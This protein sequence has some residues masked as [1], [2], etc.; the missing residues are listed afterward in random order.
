MD[1]KKEFLKIAEPPE[2]ANK[3]WY[4]RRG[5]QFER[6]LHEL[7]RM[8]LLDPRS[9]FKP[10][11]EQID[12]SFF[13][14]GNVFL[15]EA[16]WHKT[17]LPASSIYQFKGKVDGK[18][19]GTIGV[20]IS[21]SGY[22][23]DAID[24]LTLG[25]SLNVVLFGKDDINAAIVKGLGFKS[26]LKNKLRKAAEEGIVYY[27]TEI[28]EV[29]KDKSQPTEIESFSFDRI[30]NSIVEQR[31]TKEI[32][33]DLVIVC[34]GD[35]DRSILS[36]L[37]NK[38]LS[39]Y[40]SSKKIKIVVAM[41]K[42]VIPKVANALHNVAGDSVPIL[43]VADSDNDTEKIVSVFSNNINFKNWKT[44]IPEP[45]IESWLSISDIR[46]YKRS[47][48]RYL[49]EHLENLVAEIDIERL[50]ASDDAFNNFCLAV[51]K[52]EK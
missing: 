8:D 42:F 13:L 39:E 27:P 46:K 41:G 52:I 35:S 26:I 6:I 34:E 48:M 2:N 51:L 3:T 16:K 44:S 29:T 12:G 5:F 50:R 43:I 10:E 31:S 22:S 36:L 37:C 17:S 45:S 4:I 32:Y 24:A 28:E 15:L 18:L 14:N 9:G 30:T 11:G 47:R 19:Q 1:I 33:A 49:S 7:L 38:I 21:M 25:K 40:K 20:F 23:K